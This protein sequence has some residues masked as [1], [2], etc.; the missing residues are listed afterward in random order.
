MQHLP[1]LGARYLD[2]MATPM[3][4]LLLLFCLACGDDD[5]GFAPGGGGT[6]SDTG[7]SDTGA[8]TTDTGDNSGTTPDDADADG[9]PDDDDCEPDNGDVYPG[10]P[11]SCNDRDDDCD[12][13]IDEEA[14]DRPTWYLDADQDGYGTSDLSTESCDAVDGYV[15]NKADC[16]DLDPNSFPDNPEV[17]DEADNDCD[18]LVDV[19]ATDAP[20]W[21]SD[22]DGDGYGR[23]DVTLSECDQPSEFV[24]NADD[25][26]DGSA[27]TNPDAQEI[28]GDDRDNDC[29]TLI[30]DDDPEVTGTSTWF[31]DHDEDGFGDADVTTDAC[32]APSGYTSDSTDCDDLE[33]GTNP[34]AEESCDSADNDCDSSVDEGSP[35]GSQTWY[36][37]ADGDSHGDADDTV[38]ACDGPS[39]YIGDSSDCDDTDASVNPAATETC[40]GVDE[41]CNGTVDDRSTGS[42]SVCTWLNCLETLT[43]DPTSATGIYTIEP[44]YGQVFDVYCDMDTDG[45]GWTL[46]MVVNSVDNGD[47]ANA[48]SRYEDVPDLQVTPADA[49]SDTTAVSGWLNLNV[50]DYSALRVGAYASGIETWMSADIDVAE[51]R[52]DFGED[53][54]YL[55]D[56]ANGY[57]WC[58]GSA[59][60]TDNG[61]GQVETPSGGQLDCKGH[62]DLGS[63]FDLSD[64]D[65]TDQGLTLSGA[66]KGAGTMNASYGADPVSYPDPGAAYAIWVR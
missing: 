6:S 45:G 60:Y 38:E 7:G 35:P 3:T 43:D 42:G 57:Y 39:G 54:Y 23:E 11:E 12:D 32:D 30:D 46:S 20:V 47:Y 10:A 24:D 65:T 56:D 41:D 50:F 19:G 18:G 49:S 13:Q 5:P 25:C 66:T 26:D 8:A 64:Q 63:G 37:D 14:R 59:N 16:D 44:E 48:V 4:T 58:G 9:W 31:L 29:D 21:Y 2:R 28:C 17:C 33:K 36:R 34:D 1:R 15:D 61:V 53:G 55:Y 62:E 51:L 27:E 40:D 52:I 22:G